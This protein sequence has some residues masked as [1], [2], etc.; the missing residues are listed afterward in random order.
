MQPAIMKICGTVVP[1][2]R[3]QSP[4][5]ESALTWF[6]LKITEYLGKRRDPRYIHS[7]AAIN[8]YA[9]I[10]GVLKFLRMAGIISVEEC[11]FVLRYIG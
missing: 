3:R 9:E 6:E 10:V 4:D 11:N 5:I 7:A 1:K 8:D 2:N